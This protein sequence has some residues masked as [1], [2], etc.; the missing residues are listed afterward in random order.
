MPCV[1]PR[2]GSRP[3]TSGS[4]ENLDV[5]GWV[6]DAGPGGHPIDAVGV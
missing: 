4:D 2:S 5:S 3:F 6:G 1:L